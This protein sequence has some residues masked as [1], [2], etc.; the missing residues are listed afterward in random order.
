[1][2]ATGSAGFEVSGA[3]ELGALGFGTAEL[4]GTSDVAGA[5]EVGAGGSGSAAADTPVSAAVIT[6][7]AKEIDAV[8]ATD[9]A[10][11]FLFTQSHPRSP[12][13]NAQSPRAARNGIT[14]T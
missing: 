2:T 6:I 3:V 1:M 12:H 8:R 13:G 10:P 5:L 7:V 11:S 9:L 14:L 4:L